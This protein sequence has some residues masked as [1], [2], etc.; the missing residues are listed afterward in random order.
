RV[1]SA[2]LTAAEV[3]TLAEAANT[4]PVAPTADVLDVDFSDGS[5][6][7]HAQ[8]LPATTWGDPVIRDDA[9]LNR[10]VGAFDGK[11]AFLYPLAEQYDALRDGFAIECVFK[12]DDD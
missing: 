5:P 7:D 4:V 9:P 6:T 2:A 11:S 10:K 12:Y 1:Y 8:G 3:A